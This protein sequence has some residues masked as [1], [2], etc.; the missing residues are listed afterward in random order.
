MLEIMIWGD[1]FPKSIFQF[2]WD[3]AE[4]ISQGKR[5]E[6]INNVTNIGMKNLIESFWQQNPDERL[7]INDVVTT[8]ETE[9]SKLKQN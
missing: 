8:L 5:P 1:V 2:A 9:Y 3:I 7:Q 6:L 4:F